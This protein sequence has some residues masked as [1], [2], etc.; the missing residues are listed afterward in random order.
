MKL[1]EKK[2]DYISFALS[3]VITNE[4]NVQYNEDLSLEDFYRII[5]ICKKIID[6]LDE[7][8]IK[9]LLS[10]RPEVATKNYEFAKS[11]N[12]T[13]FNDGKD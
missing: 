1:D 8:D 10:V 13:I 9:L 11:I 2:C 12:K 4:D 3:C 6:V 5:D 7:E